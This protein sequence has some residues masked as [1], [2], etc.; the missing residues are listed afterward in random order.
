MI[1]RQRSVKTR[2]SLALQ[3]DRGYDRNRNIPLSYSPQCLWSALRRHLHPN[4]LI[5]WDNSEI[6]KF[7]GVI[8]AGLVWAIRC[9]VWL[10]EV[11]AW[12]A[13]H[14]E[15]LL[16]VACFL[17]SAYPTSS[18]YLRCSRIFHPHFMQL[19]ITTV[20]QRVTIQKH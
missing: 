16:A 20:I 5:V 7:P 1:E 11:V 4:P 3:L 8:D 19:V 9:H 15:D 10:G 6:A 14:L 2:D 13:Q 18:P 12:R 17:N